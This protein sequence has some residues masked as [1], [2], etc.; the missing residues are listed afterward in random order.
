MK[1][2]YTFLIS[3]LLIILI[4]G[5]QKRVSYPEYYGTWR[6]VDTPSSK[7][8][9]LSNG[10]YKCFTYGT[11]E[12]FKECR[13][14]YQ[15]YTENDTTWLKVVWRDMPMLQPGGVKKVRKHIDV[16][17][18]KLD[19]DYFTNI[20]Y[21]ARRGSLK[22][23]I[24]E[25]GVWVRDIPNPKNIEYTGKKII[26]VFPTDFKGAAWIAFNQKDGI[27]PEFDNQGNPLLRIPEN[28]IL[29]T[30]LPEDAFATANRY[31][32]IVKKDG[33]ELIPYKSFDK[34]DKIDSTFV[35]SAEDVAIMH[36]FNQR[37]REV[38]NDRVFKKEITG[39]IMSI[40]IGKLSWD[41]EHEEWTH[42]SILKM[43]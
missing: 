38:I 24:D 5:C 28:G 19:G 17:A 41:E 23:H 9:F 26:Y 2:K 11:N 21:K 13:P 32:S 39:N 8:V 3:I 7:K 20:T 43:R 30:T 36:G 10:D 16:N 18:I 1:T 35:K 4:N 14:T 12:N 25:Y 29:Q 15:F 42:P 22:N 27:P 40:Y 34:F 6:S 37:S 33:N 31:Y